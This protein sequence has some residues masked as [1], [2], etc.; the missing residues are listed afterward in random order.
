MELRQT[1]TSLAFTSK[2]GPVL[3]ALIPVICP[4]LIAVVLAFTS[5]AKV[6]GETDKIRIAAAK[7]NRTAWIELSFIVLGISVLILSR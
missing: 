3:I 2:Y 1:P 6:H 4:P 5:R 7:A